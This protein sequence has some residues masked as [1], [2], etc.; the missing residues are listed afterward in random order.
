MRFEPGLSLFSSPP[1][2]LKFKPCLFLFNTKELRTHEAVPKFE[3][4]LQKG[5]RVK[6]VQYCLMLNEKLS[7]YFFIFSV[8]SVDLFSEKYRTN[9]TVAY[10]RQI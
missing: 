1:T 4:D 6:L 7:S 8:P 5:L 10:C 3:P 2:A 9:G